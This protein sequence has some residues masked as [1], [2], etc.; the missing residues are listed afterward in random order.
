[1]FAHHRTVFGPVVAVLNT[2]STMLIPSR[3]LPSLP[4]TGNFPQPK[5]LQA[6]GL[7]RV[8][9]FQSA[10]RLRGFR[11]DHRLARFVAGHPLHRQVLGGNDA[12]FFF[13]DPMFAHSL[14]YLALPVRRRSLLPAAR[15]RAKDTRAQ[16]PSGATT[17]SPKSA[18]WKL[19]GSRFSVLR[20]GTMLSVPSRGVQKS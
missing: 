14:R 18:A 2:S 3:Y 15:N 1:M 11:I 7:R 13:Y 19:G 12:P 8:F 9:L 5:N 6:A 4:V 17:V 16:R 10:Q 20:T